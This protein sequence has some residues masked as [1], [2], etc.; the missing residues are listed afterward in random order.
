MSESTASGHGRA[1]AADRLATA[2]AV[3]RTTASSF[4]A[5]A[6]RRSPSEPSSLEPRLNKTARFVAATMRRPAATEIIR[7]DMN[8]L[9]GRLRA[10][11]VLGAKSGKARPKSPRRRPASAP[12]QGGGGP[13]EVPVMRP[14]GARVQQ[15]QP[16]RDEIRPRQ[17]RAAALRRAHGAARRKAPAPAVKPPEEP[18]E[19]SICWL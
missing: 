16:P 19:R 13:A 18:G 14:G 12:R 15:W 2:Q 1:A 9:I 7:A 6:F 4:S 8:L 5:N 17:N 11:A 3:A 10:E